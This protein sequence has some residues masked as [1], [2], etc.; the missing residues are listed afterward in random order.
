VTLSGAEVLRVFERTLE[1]GNP[2]VHVA[3]MEVRYDPRRPAGRRIRRVMLANGRALSR[4]GQY[5]VAVDDG[6]LATGALSLP[7]GALVERSRILD[8]DA[9]TIYLPRL[10]QPIEVTSRPGFVSTRP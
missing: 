4:E 9:L 5:R 8:V 10:P 3:G 2:P 6:L 1:N 7:E